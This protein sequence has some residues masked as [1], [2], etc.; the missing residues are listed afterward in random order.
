MTDLAQKMHF[1]EKSKELDQACFRCNNMMSSNRL[2][3]V[4]GWLQV[5]KQIGPIIET[6]T[7]FWKQTRSKTDKNKDLD[8]IDNSSSPALCSGKQTA[9]SPVFCHESEVILADKKTR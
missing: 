5:R 6:Q 9:T 4:N 8:N 7:A 3:A 1:W 2:R